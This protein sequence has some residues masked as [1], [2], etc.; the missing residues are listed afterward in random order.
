MRDK[1]PAIIKERDGIDA[2]IKRVNGTQEHMKYL[3]NKV[4]EEA[5]EL[6]EA[7][8]RKHIV[9]EMADVPEVIDAICEVE[10]IDKEDVLRVQDEKRQKRGGFLGGIVMNKKV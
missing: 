3:L 8:N 10:K 4:I 1:I 6:C 2:D 9:E 7:K 5:S